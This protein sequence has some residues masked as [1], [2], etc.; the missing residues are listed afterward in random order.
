MTDVVKG[1]EPNSPFLLHFRTR[2][3]A[4]LPSATDGSSVSLTPSDTRYDETLD[5]TILT[6]SGTPVPLAKSRY[7]LSTQ[8]KTEAKPEVDDDY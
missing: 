1:S 8:T 4:G 5:L 7:L 6:Q 2:V 3:L